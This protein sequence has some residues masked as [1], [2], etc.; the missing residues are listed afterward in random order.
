MHTNLV[1]RTQQILKSKYGDSVYREFNSQIQLYSGG[2]YKNWNSLPA[3]IQ[4][5]NINSFWRSVLSPL[6]N[7][8]DIRAWLNEGESIPAYIDAFD[9]NWVDLAVATG[10]FNQSKLRK[11]S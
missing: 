7:T 6:P 11:V 3:N 9:N 1:E 4:I 2:N 8:V 5:R 10:I